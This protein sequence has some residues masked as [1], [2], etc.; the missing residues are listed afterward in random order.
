MTTMPQKRA[1]MPLG[2]I[3]PPCSGNEIVVKY[4]SVCGAFNPVFDMGVTK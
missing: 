2:T 1:R 4:K 3:N